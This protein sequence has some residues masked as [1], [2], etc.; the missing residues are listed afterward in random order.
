[1]ANLPSTL[2]GDLQKENIHAAI[3]NVLRRTS[4]HGGLSHYFSKG[5]SF[6]KRGATFHLVGR[7]LN[8]GTVPESRN[9]AETPASRKTIPGLSRFLLCA[10]YMQSRLV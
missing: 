1:M 10:D 9:K 8:C 5:E 3:I 6:L 2:S 4:T 7:L